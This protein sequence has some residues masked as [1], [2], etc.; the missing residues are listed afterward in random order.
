MISN[1]NQGDVMTDNKQVQITIRTTPEEKEKISNKAKE[2]GLSVNEFIKSKILAED[3]VKD[4]TTND[5]TNDIV[6]ILKEQL[7][8]KD[9]QI[10]NLQQIIYNRDTKL[11]EAPK[12]WWQFWK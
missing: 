10:A 8:T 1:S 5:I 3:D 2:N 7:K 12:Y 9:M 11:L 6:E 4:D